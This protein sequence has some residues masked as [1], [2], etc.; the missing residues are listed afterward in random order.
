MW[1]SIIEALRVLDKCLPVRIQ[2]DNDRDFN[3]KNLSKCVWDMV[4]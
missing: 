1:F 4:S 2:T 3:S